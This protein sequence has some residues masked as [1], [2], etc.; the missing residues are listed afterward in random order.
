[1]TLRNPDDYEYD[2]VPDEEDGDNTQ[3]AAPIRPIP[4][5]PDPPT[6]HE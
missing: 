6:E 4:D 3:A 1:M 2:P 5:D